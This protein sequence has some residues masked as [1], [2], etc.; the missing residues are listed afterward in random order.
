MVCATG[1]D[2]AVEREVC[3]QPAPL[4]AAAENPDE[5]FPRGLS[6]SNLSIHRVLTHERNRADFLKVSHR[7]SFGMNFL[8]R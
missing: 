5:L 6:P 8:R 2:D 1:R 4:A 3:R 7:K